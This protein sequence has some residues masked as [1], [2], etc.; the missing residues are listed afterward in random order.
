MTLQPCDYREAGIKTGEFRCLHPQVHAKNGRITAPICQLCQFAT[1]NTERQTTPIQIPKRGVAPRGAT[2]T[3]LVIFS[4]SEDGGVVF[5]HTEVPPGTRPHYSC[6][7]VIPFYRGLEW[8]PLAIDSILSQRSVTCWVHLVNDASPEDDAWVRERYAR[9]TNITWSRNPQ[10]LGPYRSVHRVWDQMK[11]KYFAVQDADDLSLP[12][13]I[14]RALHALEKTG[15]EIYGGVM[16]QFVDCHV[17]GNPSHQQ[18]ADNFPFLKSVVAPAT[19]D[20]IRIVN[21]TMVCRR[22]AFENLNGFADM[23]RGADYEFARRAYL[24]K[25]KIF[26]DDTVVALRRV[27]DHSLSR[28]STPSIASHNQIKPPEQ[29]TL[30]GNAVPNQRSETQGRKVGALDRQRRDQTVPCIP[31]SPTG[32]QLTLSQLCSLAPWSSTAVAFSYLEREGFI[33]PKSKRLPA[34]MPVESIADFQSYYNR[35]R[36]NARRDA[37]LA[38]RAG[39]YCRAMMPENHPVD[40]VEIVHSMPN[41]QGRPMRDTVSGLFPNGALHPQVWADV[42]PIRT[43]HLYWRSFG[44]FSTCPG[45]R[46]GELTVNEKLLAFITLSRKGDMAFYSMIMGH[47]DFLKYGIMQALH[48]HVMKWL[49][50]RD[51][52]AK[53]GIKYL[54]YS[55]WSDVKA[56]MRLWK[57]RAGFAPYCLYDADTVPAQMAASTD[58][59]FPTSTLQSANSAAAFFCAAFGGQNDAVHYLNHGIKDVS[60]IDQQFEKLAG[61]RKHY[62]GEWNYFLCDAFAAVKE[63]R[64]RRSFDVVSCDQWSSQFDQVAGKHFLSFYE[65]AKQYLL[66]TVVPNWA[67]AKQHGRSW[68]QANGLDYVMYLKVRDAFK[69]LH[70]TP[71][72]LSNVFSEQHGIPLTV[73]EVVHRTDF[74]GGCYW[75]VIKK[76]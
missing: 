59:P 1:A 49:L 76:K 39:Y 69:T 38:E 52:E 42:S 62:P 20:K 5:G 74:L 48:L 23:Q 53:R 34:L 10:N 73:V 31:P 47:R 67:D 16:E 63:L 3:G 28:C 9:H 18:Y 26:I 27:H 54:M 17:A 8:L 33:G 15:C 71:R 2:P 25:A 11:S 21:G 72:Y 7:V 22:A 46:Q 12:T 60:L 55:S 24:A 14:W 45:H 61:M 66:I 68:F 64:G 50:Q 32:G 56:G 4:R 75:I 43:P 70:D 41:R 30:P 44:L 36:S 58:R 51:E 19:K 35:L 65:L 13:R 29:L 40:M 6:D 57:Q 37:R